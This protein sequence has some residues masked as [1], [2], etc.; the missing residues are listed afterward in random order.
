M[1]KGTATFGEILVSKLEAFN[2][3]TE[4]DKTALL[5]IDV[6]P[7]RFR[8]GNDLVLEGDAPGGVFVIVE[9]F[10]CRYKVS[11]RGV[12]Q[13]IAYLL[14]GDFCDLDILLLSSM[15][16]SIGTL[17]ECRVAQL[18]SKTVHDLSNHA[19]LVRAFRKATLIE[20][21]NAREWL[22]NLGGRSAVARVAHL[23]CELHARLQVVGLADNHSFDLPL[24]QVD[25]A[26][27]MGMSI[28]HMNR[29]LKEL[30]SAGFINL[31]RSRLT[32]CNPQGLTAFARFKSNYLHFDEKVA[33]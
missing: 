27:A 2:P 30:R 1:S 15:D 12:R 31:K 5:A 16:H 9:G 13:I 6:E 4:D 17:S 7:R 11:V 33:A 29:S 32:I 26:D 22:V 20:T 3:L 28:V 14:P 10:A 25:L 23:F 18:P 21:A 19:G 8:A 24:T